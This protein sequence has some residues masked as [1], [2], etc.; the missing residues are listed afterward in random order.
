[1]YEYCNVCTS[2]IVI[3][4]VVCVETGF[5]VAMD[6]GGGVFAIQFFFRIFIALK[7]FQHFR[8]SQLRYLLG[9]HFENNELYEN[10]AEHF[11]P[12]TC[13]RHCVYLQLHVCLHSYTYYV[14]THICMFVC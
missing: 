2:C 7:E 5:I 10:Y 6:S 1:M 4:V 8:G 9:C 11:A 14:H 3:T 13:V 12:F